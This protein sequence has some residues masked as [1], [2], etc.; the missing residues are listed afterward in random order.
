MFAA[1]P[2]FRDPGGES[3]NSPPGRAANWKIRPGSRNLVHNLPPYTVKFG[4][5]R[6][7]LFPANFAV[8][9]LT[10]EQA[11]ARLLRWAN[12]TSNNKVTK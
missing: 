10:P 4:P 3:R 6:E 5:V 8:I 9:L 2:N 7:L 12:A 11:E 1:G